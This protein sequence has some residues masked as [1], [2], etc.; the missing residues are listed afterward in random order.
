M[1]LR[2]GSV[3]VG[4]RCC[5]EF[6]LVV[7]KEFSYYLGKKLEGILVML[8]FYLGLDLNFLFRVDCCIV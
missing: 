4:C 8:I 3:I 1:G 7:W 6:L 5:L 2:V